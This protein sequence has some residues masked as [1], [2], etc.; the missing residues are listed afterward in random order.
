[1]VSKEKKEEEE[2]EDSKEEGEEEGM[3]ASANEVQD[4][5]RHADQPRK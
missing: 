5:G 2:E 3:L 1:M 4:V